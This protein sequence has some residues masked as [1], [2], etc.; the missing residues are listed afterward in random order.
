[1]CSRQIFKQQTNKLRKKPLN[2]LLT[3]GLKSCFFFFFN[4]QFHLRENCRLL[5]IPQDWSGFLVFVLIHLH[6]PEFAGPFSKR[7]S[8]MFVTIETR[9]AP[10]VCNSLH[11]FPPLSCFS[12]QLNCFMWHFMQNN[13]CLFKSFMKQSFLTS[14][15]LL[16]INLNH[17]FG[18]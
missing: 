15:V 1:M 18:L 6:L 9:S 11:I 4:L 14:N 17:N 5:Y 10:F 13:L 7:Y 3:I 2:R 8:F 12:S 16:Y